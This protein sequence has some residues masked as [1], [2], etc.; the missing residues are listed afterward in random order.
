MT[1]SSTVALAS[2]RAA[3]LGTGL[4]ATLAATLLA[5]SACGGGTSQL[6]P[7]VAQRVFAFGDDTSAITDTG[8]KY[9]VNGL[10]TEGNID[11]NAEPLWVQSVAAAYG[12][13][14]SQCNPNNADASKAR[15]YAAAGAKVADVSAQVDAQVAAGGFRD[16]DLALVLAGANDVLAL[17]AQY[18]AQ[19]E[20]TLSSQA[21]DRGEALARVVNRL[22]GLGVKVIVST[23]PN[24]GLSPYARAEETA[25]PGRAAIITRLTNAFNEQLGLRIV[26]DGRLVGLMQ[27]DLR[28]QLIERF[29]GG[30]GFVDLNKAVCTVAL[31]NCTTA[32][33]V[34]E[35]TSGAF[36]WA[37]ATR[38]SSSMQGQLATLALERAQRN[39]F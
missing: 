21:R 37:D 17:Y 4:V 26:P 29:P 18:P 25:N 19:S 36:F 2:S 12:L 13:V 30:Y 22:T 34:P 32:T 11:C 3:A 23:L 9:A 6:E 10:N 5:L 35:A 39:P 8:R 16:K 15:L 27:T 28:S 33:L 7:F 24:Y 20:A 14:F 38:L 31:P 1:F